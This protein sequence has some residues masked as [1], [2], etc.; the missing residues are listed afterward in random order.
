MPCTVGRFS[1]REW[2]GITVPI[3][4]TPLP[5]SQLEKESARIFFVYVITPP[6]QLKEKGCVLIKS[7]FQYFA[8]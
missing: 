2:S 8:S 5:L 1:V 3:S 7:A 4:R 6:T